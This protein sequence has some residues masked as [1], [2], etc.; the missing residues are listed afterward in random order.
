[1]ITK[2]LITRVITMHVAALSTP[3]RNNYAALLSAWPPRGH[4][5]PPGVA[6]VAVHVAS[7]TASSSVADRPAVDVVPVPS[8]L[9]VL[10]YG[11]SRGTAPRHGGTSL[12]LTYKIYFR[13]RS[14]DVHVTIDH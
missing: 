10:V 13:D 2:K 1:M 6:S 3:G 8:C 9:A 4:A 7:E 12:S 14:T 11:G 5:R